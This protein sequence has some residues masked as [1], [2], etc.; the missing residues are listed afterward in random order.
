MPDLPNAWGAALRLSAVALVAWGGWRAGS[1]SVRG[2]VAAAVVGGCAMAGGAGPGALLVGWFLWTVGWSRAGR[3]RKR[4]RTGGVV[5]KG[6]ARDPWQ[7]AANGGVYALAVLVAV[8]WPAVA[9]VAWM[10]AAGALAAA[11]ADTVATEV[12]TWVGGEPWSLRT[13]TRVPPGTSGA[14]TVAGTLALGVSALVVAALAAALAVV[15]WDAVGAVAVA[16]GAGALA[17]TV[18]G[19][20]VQLR[21]WCPACAKPTEQDPHACGAVTRRAGGWRW[22]DNDAV[23]LLATVVGAAVAV[24]LAP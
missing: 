18:A 19:A 7:V 1:L 14:V 3:A 16:G 15:P 17:D 11:G 5:A 8:L 2:A 20:W 22:M 6:G 13:R 10:A 24:L 12:G 4:A 21:R 23:N 9:P